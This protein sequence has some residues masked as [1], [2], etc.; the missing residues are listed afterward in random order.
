MQD[1]ELSKGGFEMIESKT[2]GARMGKFTVYFLLTL[3]AFISLAPIVNTVALSFSD[4]A[5]A[6]AGNVYFW[7]KGFTFASYQ[8][9]LNDDAFISAFMVSVKRVILGGGLNMILCILMAFPLS[10]NTK[11]FKYRNFYMWFL[12]FTMIFSGGIVPT[13]IIISKLGLINSIWALVL[14]GAVPVFNVILLMNFFRGIPDSLEEA[15]VIDGASPLTVLWKIFLPI[16]LP[17]L[18]T[19]AL[20]TIVAHWNSFFDGLIYINDQNKIPLQ[21]YLQQL[22]IQTQQAAQGQL[23]SDELIALSKM[24]TL[25]LNSAKILVSMIPIL[26]V[27]PF[28]QRYL[29]H[30]LV[31]GSVKE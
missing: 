4:S 11:Q 23:S 16:S 10:R 3:A 27:Y 26:L 19:I 17:S 21:T 30:G 8:K 12:M 1:T 24:S 22:V 20:F 6:S 9:I 25:T 15:A 13:Y 31:L 7:P 29:I 28:L 2:L 18:A 14:P 5:A